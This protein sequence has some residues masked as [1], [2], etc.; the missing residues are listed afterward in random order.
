MQSPEKNLFQCDY[1]TFTSKTE[2]EMK[3][4]KRKYNITHSKLDYNEHLEEL[5]CEIFALKEIGFMLLG[6][7]HYDSYQ[8]KQWMDASFMTL[9]K[10]PR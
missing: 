10:N 5:N 2:S 8:W 3:T 1:C 9:G 4:H 7:Q 6:M